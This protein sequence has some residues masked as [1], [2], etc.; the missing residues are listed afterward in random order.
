MEFIFDARIAYNTILIAVLLC[1]SLLILLIVKY[2]VKKQKKWILAIVMIALLII[3]LVFLLSDV[4]IK[5]FPLW[6][7]IVIPV[8]IF[9]PLFTFFLGQRSAQQTYN[10]TLQKQK[11]RVLIANSV[12][13]FFSAI[14]LMALYW[15]RSQKFWTALF[16]QIL[17][18]ILFLFFSN[19]QLFFPKEKETTEKDN[20]K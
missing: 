4:S 8:A 12:F 17:P 1:I 13:I 7:V 2:R 9:I 20:I 3:I 14:I 19:F 6:V 15:F 18:M 16:I 11:K 5:E 10:A